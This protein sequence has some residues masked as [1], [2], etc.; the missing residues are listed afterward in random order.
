MGT[1]RYAS[2]KSKEMAKS[3]TFIEFLTDLAVSIRKLGAAMKV[4]SVDRSMIG[5]QLPSGFG[6]RK[7]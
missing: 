3:P 5:R 4:L 2:V 6:T 1:W 7:R